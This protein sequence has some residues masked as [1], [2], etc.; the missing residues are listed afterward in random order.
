VKLTAG[1]PAVI[2]MQSKRFDTYLRL[3]D[4]KGKTLAE[5]DD[6]DTAPQ[7]CWGHAGLFGC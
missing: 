7:T 4:A 6:I 1:K 3:E 2:E 5:N